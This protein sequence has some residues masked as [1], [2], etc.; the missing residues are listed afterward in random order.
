MGRF[1]SCFGLPDACRQ[2]G[3]WAR[4]STCGPSSSI[5]WAKVTERLAADRARLRGYAVS[6]TTRSGQGAP[7][8]ASKIPRR[9][10]KGRKEPKRFSGNTIRST[11]RVAEHRSL[12]LAPGHDRFLVRSFA[13]GTCDDSQRDSKTGLSKSLRTSLNPVDYKVAVQRRLPGRGYFSYPS[14]IERIGESSSESIGTLPND[15]YRGSFWWGKTPRWAT[16]L[17]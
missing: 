10:A 5:P 3:G 13:G 16:D 9:L 6:S 15:S 4:R 11:S 2:P 17:L 8:M 1:L 12:L 14:V 7:S